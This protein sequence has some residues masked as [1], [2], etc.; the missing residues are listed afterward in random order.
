MSKSGHT[1]S[2]RRLYPIQNDLWSSQLHKRSISR[3]RI[4]DKGSF[5]TVYGA[6]HPQI[7]GQSAIKVS[8]LKPVQET[9]QDECLLAS[10]RHENVLRYY[11]IFFDPA[12]RRT[13]LVI[14]H[15]EGES[16]MNLLT[17]ALE[18]HAG[19]H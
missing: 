15:V 1:A 4:I 6:I 13:A 7:P 11:C 18:N 5:A 9:R 10:I 14:E 19:I 8:K 3:A 16:I 2:G 12:S 17:R